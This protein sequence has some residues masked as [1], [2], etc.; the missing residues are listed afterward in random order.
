[1]YRA[2]LP[3]ASAVVEYV[4]QTQL[5]CFPITGLLRLILFV[6]SKLPFSKKQL[7]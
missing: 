5:H 7:K 4:P 2:F 6:A 3:A 1:M